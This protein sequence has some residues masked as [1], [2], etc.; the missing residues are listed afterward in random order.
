MASLQKEYMCK[1]CF[2]SNLRLR[3]PEIDFVFLECVNFY[4]F[5]AFFSVSTFSFSIAILFIRISSSLVFLQ[6]EH[7]YPL[8]L[9]K[10]DILDKTAALNESATFQYTDEIISK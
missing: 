10:T 8:S 1:I 9:L 6:I 7:K 4:P 3:L 2:V 5:C